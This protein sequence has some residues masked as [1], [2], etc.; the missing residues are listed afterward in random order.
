MKPGKSGKEHPCAGCIHFYG[1]YRANK[2]CN[3]LFDTGRRRPC[4][5]GSACTVKF[6]ATNQNPGYKTFL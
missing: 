6:C 2:C 3:Y 1:A 5:P 4:P